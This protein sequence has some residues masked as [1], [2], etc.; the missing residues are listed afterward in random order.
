MVVSTP[1]GLDMNSQVSAIGDA[2]CPEEKINNSSESARRAFFMLA[3]RFANDI[4]FSYI[5]AE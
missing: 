1:N 2:A 3:D 5:V 4:L